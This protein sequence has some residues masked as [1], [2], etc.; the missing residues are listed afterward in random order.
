[1]AKSR[2]GKPDMVL[3]W[4]YLT[5]VLLGW[6][7]YYSVTYDPDRTTS[8][9]D[10]SQGIGKETLWVGLALVTFF[11]IQMMDVRI[12]SGFAFVL[13]GIGLLLLLGVLFLGTNIKGATSWY[14]FAGISFQPSEFAKFGTALAVSSLL[15]GPSEDMRQSRTRW[16]A[17]AIIAL[18]MLL[19][20]LQ[21]D[22]GS[23]LVF[24]SFFILFYR[25]GL[26]AQLYV[27]GFVLI[28]LFILSLVWDTYALS[29]VI[30]GLGLMVTANRQDTGLLTGY[31]LPAGALLLGLFFPHSKWA[32]LPLAALVLWRIWSY[33]ATG[34]IK[35]LMAHSVIV[36][37]ALGVVFGARFFYDHVL[38]PHQQE[39]INVWL[40]PSKCDPRGSLYNVL[41]SKMAIGS[42]GLMGRGMLKG[43]LT[44]LN[45]V[46]EQ[47]TDFIFCTI[48]EEHGFI[49]TS[50][51]ILVYLFFVLRLLSLAERQRFSFAKN[52]GYALAGILFFHF[53]INIGMTMGLFPIIGIPLPLV[54]YGGTSLLMFTIMIA[55]MIKLDASY[56]RAV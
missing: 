42:G 34:H 47:S 32:A 52:Y 51:T 23:A 4:L 8:V 46:P 6:V 12:W 14:S 21:P 25:K 27:I 44:R 24:T 2:V 50:I 30:L 11:V 31:V 41:Q 49:G 39:R 19:I 17:L 16:L 22:A 56:H 53:L 29:L 35:R 5:L 48:G 54:S 37:L 20:L 55:V 28:A 15:A 36:G 1:M 43:E 3:T 45:Y 33:L 9:F 10:L 38:E 26:P 7:L 40:N 18:P 13:Y